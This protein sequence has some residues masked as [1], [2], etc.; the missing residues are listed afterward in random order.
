[1]TRAEPHPKEG[2]QIA[3][4]VLD[5]CGNESA[6]VTV[7]PC[8]SRHVT[9][10]VLSMLHDGAGTW[11]VCKLVKLGWYVAALRHDMNVHSRA[12]VDT[13]WH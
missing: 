5:R 13:W 7:C 10:R 12:Q 8:H 9:G 11:Q 3:V 4:L 2:C 1:M 6:C